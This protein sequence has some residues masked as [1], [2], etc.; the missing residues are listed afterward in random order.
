MFKGAAL[1]S[2]SAP[3]TCTV[4]QQSYCWLPE[5]HWCRAIALRELYDVCGHHC[6]EIHPID[7]ATWGCTSDTDSG[8]NMKASRLDVVDEPEMY[9]KSRDF[10]DG[11]AVPFE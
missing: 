9:T 5:D 3:C 4:P 11:V 10:R 7:K 8:W 1:Y 6:L 2:E